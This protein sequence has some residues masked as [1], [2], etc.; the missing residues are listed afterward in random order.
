MKRLAKE[1]P[2]VDG[3]LGARTTSLTSAFRIA[4]SSVTRQG[5]SVLCL[6]ILPHTSSRRVDG[7]DG[8]LADNAAPRVRRARTAA[9]DDKRGISASTP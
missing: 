8:T 7:V 2:E 5:R 1:L 3:A 4:D 9:S 6:N